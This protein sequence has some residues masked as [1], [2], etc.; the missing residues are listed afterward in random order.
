MVKKTEVNTPET[1]FSKIIFLGLFA[2]I[3]CPYFY[4]L[5][6]IFRLIKLALPLGNPDWSAVIQIGA[7]FF[8]TRGFSFASNYIFNHRTIDTTAIEVIKARLLEWLQWCLLR[9]FL[10]HFFCLWISGQKALKSQWVRFRL[11]KKAF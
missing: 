7:I 10:G 1:F 4:V 6:F 5:T 11:L 2:V 8:V 3:Y 9:F